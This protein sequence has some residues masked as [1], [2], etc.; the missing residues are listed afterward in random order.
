MSK[1]KMG[2]ACCTERE[3]RV[4]KKPAARA[5]KL[6]ANRKLDHPVT[7][8]KAENPEEGSPDYAKTKK[9]TQLPQV[10]VHETPTDQDD[11]LNS[12]KA[13]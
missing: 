11:T 2:A 13:R 9:G 12:A 3:N 8:S 4:S 7:P 5:T 6:T 1:I 10:M